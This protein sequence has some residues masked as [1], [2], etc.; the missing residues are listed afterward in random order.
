MTDGS[1]NPLF[2]LRQDAI[3]WCSTMQILKMKLRRMKS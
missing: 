1:E 3:D 2:E